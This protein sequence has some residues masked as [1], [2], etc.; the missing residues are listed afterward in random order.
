MEGWVGTVMGALSGGCFRALCGISVLSGARLS[1]TVALAEV[2]GVF[3]LGG[4]LLKSGGD[5]AEV[6]RA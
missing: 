6:Y 3:K 4:A 2:V 1:G 5:C